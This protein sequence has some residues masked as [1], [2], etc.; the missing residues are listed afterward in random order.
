MARDLTCRPSVRKKQFDLD[1]E[2]RKTLTRVKA[3]I[4]LSQIIALASPRLRTSVDLSRSDAEL[5]AVTNYFG[6][7][8]VCAL[9]LS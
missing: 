1:L 8:H 4:P 2:E 7:C 9:I 5:A 3:C 6:H